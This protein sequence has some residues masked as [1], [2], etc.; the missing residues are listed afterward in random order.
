M[1]AVF[2]PVESGVYWTANIVVSPG[3]SGEGGGVTTKNSAE[4]APLIVIAETVR[5]SLPELG[6]VSVKSRRS[7]L[8]GGMV[9]NS[10]TPPSGIMAV[11]PAFPITIFAGH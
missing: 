4:F 5:L 3:G 11:L 7:V 8:P 6:F 1:T 2:L 9:S 10:T